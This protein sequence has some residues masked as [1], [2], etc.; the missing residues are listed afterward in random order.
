MRANMDNAA[1][2]AGSALREIEGFL[3]AQAR[4]L[5]ANAGTRQAHAL[6]TRQS[7]RK[8]EATLHEVHAQSNRRL[9]VH[10]KRR[11]HSTF[12]QGIS[13]VYASHVRCNSYRVNTC[14]AGQLPP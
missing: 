4:Q 7:L 5:N 14:Q 1:R 11:L 10:V 13:N 12:T 6:Q 8:W 9:D 2:T 3:S